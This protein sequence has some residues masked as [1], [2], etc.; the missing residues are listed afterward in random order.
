[1]S[2]EL[3]KYK[4]ISYSMSNIL[5]EYTRLLYS[6][7]TIYFSQSIYTENKDKSIY[8]K[9]N[10]FFIKSANILSNVFMF[11]LCKTNNIEMATVN[12]QRGYK[13]CI[14]HINA[15]HTSIN[16][17]IC[18]K[19]PSSNLTRIIYKKTICL[20]KKK[21]I[22]NIPPNILQKIYDHNTLIYSN[23]MSNMTPTN[24]IECIQLQAP[25]DDSS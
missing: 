16:S 10:D 21:D 18:I 9:Y 24:A 1:M 4:T 23:I 20:I 12:Y 25:K 5:H 14:D 15:F 17:K 22:Y 19:L 3:S 8:L 7:T 13:I 6:Y 11:I 2:T